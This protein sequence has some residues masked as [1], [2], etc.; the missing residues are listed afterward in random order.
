MRHHTLLLGRRPAFRAARA[1]YS[2]RARASAGIVYS[3]G[4]TSVDRPYSAAVAAVIGPMDATAI[5]PR[6][7][8]RS[9]S[10]N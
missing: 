6:Q 2:A 5:R 8:L 7:A 3:L 4:M 10:L 1:K 9:A